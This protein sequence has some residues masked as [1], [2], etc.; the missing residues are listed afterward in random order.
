MALNPAANS[1]VDPKI[2]SVDSDSIPLVTT[3]E[4]K[5]KVRDLTR[6]QFVVWFLL[7]PLVFTAF[8]I[9]NIARRIFNLFAACGCCHKEHKY[10]CLDAGK[11]LLKIFVTP[12]AVVGFEISAF[13]GIFYPK[14]GN[15]LK[16]K[17]GENVFAVNSNQTK[18]ESQPHL[19]QPMSVPAKPM[20]TPD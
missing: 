11:D 5:K 7:G 8:G 10:S 2:H 4:G 15:W 19:Q 3:T 12:P 14:A 18:S 20:D 17:I 6:G 1:S 13:C 9:I 16:Q